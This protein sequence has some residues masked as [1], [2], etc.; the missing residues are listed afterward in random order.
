LTK[1]SENAIFKIEKR[2]DHKNKE[3]KEEQMRKLTEWW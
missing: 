3:K 1:K 2:I